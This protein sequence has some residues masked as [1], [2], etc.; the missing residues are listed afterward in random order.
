[1]DVGR[2][3]KVKVRHD[4]SGPGPGWFLDWV[5]VGIVGEKGAWHFPCGRWLDVGEGDGVIECELRVREEKKEEEEERD[6]GKK[7]ETKK[8]EPIMKQVLR[9]VTHCAGHVLASTI[10]HLKKL[11]Y[12]VPSIREHTFQAVL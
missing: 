10:I 7:K 11:T 2:V 1:M 9:R 4:N 12:G 8:G 5:E 6:G 3:E